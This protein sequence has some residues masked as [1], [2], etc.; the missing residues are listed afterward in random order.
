MKKQLIEEINR[1]KKLSGILINE[2]TG[3]KA[4]AD[5][6]IS[7]LVKTGEKA[8]PREI[9]TF[10]TKTGTKAVLNVSAYKN[11]LTK[12]VLNADEKKLLH[13]INKN[14]VKDMGGEFFVTAIKDVTKGLGRLE[15]IALESKILNEFFDATTSEVIKSTCSSF[16]SPIN[17]NNL[18][19]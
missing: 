16:L 5:I 6:L 11:L 4:L 2:N 12:S 9:G 18:P 15:S 8:L 1:F 13:T 10:T 3:E 19:C 7:R 17:S 14:I